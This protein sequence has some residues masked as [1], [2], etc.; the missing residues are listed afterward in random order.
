MTGT[1]P[2]FWDLEDEGYTSGMALDVSGLCETEM[3]S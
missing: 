2:A 1:P 3:P